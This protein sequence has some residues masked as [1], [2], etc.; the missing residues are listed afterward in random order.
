MGGLR[1]A[2]APVDMSLAPPVAPR[3]DQIKQLGFYWFYG[4][5]ATQRSTGVTKTSH[6][7]TEVLLLAERELSDYSGRKEPRLLEGKSRR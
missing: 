7:N 3:D 1:G 6:P 2:L 5:N 4:P